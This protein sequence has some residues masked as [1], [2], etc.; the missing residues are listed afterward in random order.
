MPCC[1]LLDFELF[2]NARMKEANF[3]PRGENG[4]AIQFE[5]HSQNAVRRRVL[6]PH[7]QRHLA[8]CTGGLVRNFQARWIRYLQLMLRIERF[9]VCRAFFHRWLFILIRILVSV[10]RIIFAQWM[11]LPNPPAS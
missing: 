10:N 2:F 5:H 4:F 9:D 11:A 8:R 3:R 7:V 1:V 6:R